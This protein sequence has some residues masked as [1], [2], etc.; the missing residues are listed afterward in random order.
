MGAQHTWSSSK[1]QSKPQDI[2]WGITHLMTRKQ[3][4]Q[5]WIQLTMNR[6]SSSCA[7]PIQ[8]YGGFKPFL[9]DKSDSLSIALS[10]YTLFCHAIH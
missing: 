4:L 6:D 1:K 2:T 7:K 3:F 9:T 10:P 8:R 5:G